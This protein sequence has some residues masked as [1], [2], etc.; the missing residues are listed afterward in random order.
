LI[1]LATPASATPVRQALI[2]STAGSIRLFT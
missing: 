1:S 2:S